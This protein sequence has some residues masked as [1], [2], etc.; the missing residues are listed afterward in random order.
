M[1]IEEQWISL[2]LRSPMASVFQ[3]F[4]WA[5]AWYESYG[6]NKD[7]RIVVGFEDS[8]ICF[9]MPLYVEESR[10]WLRLR[11]NTM[12]FIGDPRSDYLSVIYDDTEKHH[13]GMLLEY[14]RKE[15]TDC[16]TYKFFNVL[17]EIQNEDSLY[18]YLDNN[19]IYYRVN[20][21]NCYNIDLSISSPILRTKT[22]NYSKRKLEEM[23]EL[24][25]TVYKDEQLLK[26]RLEIFFESHILQWSQKNAPSMFKNELNKDFYRNLVKRLFKHGRLHFSELQLNGQHIAVHFGFVY[27]DRF[28]YYKPT[29]NIDYSKFSPGMLLMIRLIEETSLRGLQFFDFLRG[30]ETYKVRLSNNNN[31]ITNTYYYSRKKG[32]IDKAIMKIKRLIK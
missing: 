1:D 32:N 19:M 24:K 16:Y 12:R 5:V 7:L 15:L 23:G 29:Y 6:K 25:Y 9:I 28:Y 3:T 13:W 11:S 14:L 26:E 10:N 2:V 21:E 18:S 17:L 20:P 8:K 30:D 27:T 4:E 31:T 22:L